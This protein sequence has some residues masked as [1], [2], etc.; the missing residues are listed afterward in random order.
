VW[1]S[2]GMTLL[3]GARVFQDIGEAILVPCSLALIKV[4]TKDADRNSAIAIW[5]AGASVAVAAGL[6]I[7]DVF[8]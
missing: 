3:I 8:D 4:F 2:T 6:V 7:G 1:W 5:A